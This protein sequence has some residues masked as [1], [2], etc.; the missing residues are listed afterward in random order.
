MTRVQP[1]PVYTR[2]GADLTREV[3]ITL[4]EALLGAEITVRT[5][6]GRVR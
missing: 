6:K 5:L 1:H 4:G 2:I 3:P